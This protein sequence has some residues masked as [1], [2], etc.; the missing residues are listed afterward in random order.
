ML[1]F[2]F[3]DLVP[4]TIISTA[5]F[6]IR[7]AMSISLYLLAHTPV[8]R[9]FPDFYFALSRRVL[10]VWRR[11]LKIGSGCCQYIFIRGP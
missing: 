4:Q 8:S 6:Y 7:H 1:P 11:R 5:F 3:I 9:D 2:H 10:E